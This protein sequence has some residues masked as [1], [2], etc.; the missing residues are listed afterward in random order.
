[1]YQNPVKRITKTSFN[2]IFTR[3]WSQCLTHENIVNGFRAT[4]LYPFNPDILPDE[5]YIPSILT[6]LPLPTEPGAVVD[7]DI[8]EQPQ[9]NGDSPFLLEQAPHSPEKSSAQSATD[10]HALTVN[11]NQQ[12]KDIVQSSERSLVM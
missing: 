1:M 5:A 7:S 9:H 10:P 8:E 12:H 4:G 11:T 6:E 3:V 2:A